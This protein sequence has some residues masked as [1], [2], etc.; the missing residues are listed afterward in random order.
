MKK[1][2]IVFHPYENRVGNSVP[3]GQG[4]VAGIDNGIN[5]KI[6]IKQKGWKDKD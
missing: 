6:C 3:F 5:D 2:L 4:I 1:I